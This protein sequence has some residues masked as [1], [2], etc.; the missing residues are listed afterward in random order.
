MKRRLHIFT[1]GFTPEFVIR[2]L[3]EFGVKESDYIVVLYTLTGDEYSEKRLKEAISS[4]EMFSRQGGFIERV[5]F[6][7]VSLR[8]SF[9]DVV[10]GVASSIASAMRQAQLFRDVLEE[11]HVWLTGGM[12]ILVVATLNAS[13]MLFSYLG[14]P[15]KYHLWSEDSVYKYHFE[16]RHVGIDLR[17][18]PRS[19]LALLEKIVSLGEARYRELVD[20]SLKEGTVRKLAELLRAKGLIECR[21]EDKYTV[22]TATELGKLVASM[23]SLA[24]TLEI[25]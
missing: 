12:R 18:I 6:Q 22:C 10:Y 11:I 17:D 5:Y 7:Q 2:P 8:R 14:V 23:I 20:T 15:V 24:E 25:K 21:R 9:S 13:R 1:L 19:Q 3:L 16:L 4:I